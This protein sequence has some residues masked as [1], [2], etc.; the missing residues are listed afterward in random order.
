MKLAVF[1]M[2]GTLLNG[3][4]IFAIADKWGFRDKVINIMG[5]NLLRYEK[6]I[7]IAKLLAGLKIADVEDVIRSVPLMPG[8]KE[9]ACEL[10]KRGYKLGI[11]SDSYTVAT[12]YLA[13]SLGFDFHVANELEVKNGVLTGNIFMPLGWIEENCN[14]FQSVCKAFYLKY[15]ALKMNIS[16][17]DSIA[18]GDGVADL[19]MIKKAGIGIAFNPKDPILLQ[20]AKIIINQPDLREI[21]KY[22]R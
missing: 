18:I 8:A 5:S 7:R 2:D 3:R 15:Y 9:V 14:C 1:D 17:S 16:L 13:E 12:S 11:I 19:C 6:S 21:L 22:L 4:V 10:K 20:Y